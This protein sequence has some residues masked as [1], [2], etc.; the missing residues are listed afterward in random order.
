MVLSCPTC[1]GREKV[2]YTGN[3]SGTLQFNHVSANAPGGRVVT[4]WY[5]NGDAVFYALLSV[6]GGAG[7]PVS[8]PSTG[9]FQTV[10]SVQ[11]TVTL[12]AGSNNTLKFYNPIIGSWAPDFNRIGVNCH[13]IAPTDLRPQKTC[14]SWSSPS[15]RSLTLNFLVRVYSPARRS[16]LRGWV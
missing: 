4:I 16:P 6:N 7:T 14:L 2:G 8:F 11:R 1:S 5:T 10:G 12:N 13:I 3:N 15:V 9:S